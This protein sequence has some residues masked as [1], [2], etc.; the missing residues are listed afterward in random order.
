MTYS[1]HVKNGQILLDSPA[2]LQEGAAVKIEVVEPGKNN[3]LQGQRKQ[4]RF[5]PI[6]MPGGPL[7]DDIIRERR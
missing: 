6:E 5:Q 7:A 4:R 3:Q 1:G 2:A